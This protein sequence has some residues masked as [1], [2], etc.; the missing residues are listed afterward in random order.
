VRHFDEVIK[1]NLNSHRK[2]RGLSVA[3]TDGRLP[4]L[5]VDVGNVFQENS[6]PKTGTTRLALCRL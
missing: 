1:A 3:D 6:A 2:N 4:V 5:P